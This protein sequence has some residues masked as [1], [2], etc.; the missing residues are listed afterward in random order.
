MKLH[1]SDP[2]LRLSNEGVVGVQTVMLA[3]LQE[4][5]W[6]TTNQTSNEGLNTANLDHLEKILPQLV[7]I[8]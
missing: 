1:A 5:I 7:L 2:K 6:R 4:I 3:F 8:S